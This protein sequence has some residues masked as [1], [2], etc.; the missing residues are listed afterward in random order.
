MKLSAYNQRL[1][2]DIVEGN[3]DHVAYR[4]MPQIESMLKYGKSPTQ[5]RYMDEEIRQLAVI[6]KS[7]NAENKRLRDLRW[8]EQAAKYGF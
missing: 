4:L 2:D 5:R 7:A 3:F 8:A 1:F 6:I